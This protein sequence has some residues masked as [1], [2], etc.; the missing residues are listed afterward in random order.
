MDVEEIV[1]GEPFAQ[2]IDRTLAGCSAALI[3]I[4][5]KWREVLGK[6][7]AE[8]APDYVCHEIEA[9]LARKIKVIPVLVGG[10]AASC[11]A[12]LPEPLTAL[13]GFQ[14]VELRD[15]SF[16]EDCNRLAAGIRPPRGTR[17]VAA[18]AGAAILLLALVFLAS[19]ALGVGPWGEYRKRQAAVRDQL[20]TAK[21]QMDRTEYEAAFRTCGAVLKTEPASRPAMDLQADAAMRWAED[22]SV[23]VPEGAKQE[24]LAGPPLA[25]IMTVLDAALARTGGKGTRAGDILAHLGWAHWLN[26][27]LA[28]KEYG[29]NAEQDLRRALEVDPNN[30]FAHAMLGNWLLQTGGDSAEALR[31][32]QAA[33]DTKQERPLVRTMQLGAL[34]YNDDPGMRTAL[35]RAAND[36]R[37][38]GEAMQAGQ[39]HRIL[40]NYDPTVN[41]GEE[42]KETLSA[43]PPEDAWATYLWLDNRQEKGRS[44][45]AQKVNHEFIQDNLLEISGKKPEA[46]AAFQSLKQQL[47]QQGFNGRIADH[48][49]AA[50]Q[51]LSR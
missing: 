3:V 36:M 44:G 11:L 23:L 16:G 21:T 2:A 28:F 14:A 22:F 51:R 40:S 6:R 20:A 50:I 37:R 17:R 48:V 4:G 43:V 33:V 45:E 1:P 32:F 15:S 26:Q 12:G 13:S 31:H 27:K 19:G 38:N 24:D 42:L 35:I 5:P 7:S 49:A 10:A 34:I 18:V 25:E 30:V 9:V 8:S 29:A 46:L 39:A 47:A 41:S